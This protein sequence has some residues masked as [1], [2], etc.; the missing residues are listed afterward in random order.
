[1]KLIITEEM[2]YRKKVV[3]YAIKYQ[4]NAQAARRYGTS[5]QNVKRW[6]DRYDGTW[7][8][9]RPLSRR[10]NSHSKQHTGNELQLIKKTYQRY[11]H[12]GLAEVYVQCKQRGYCRTYESMCKQIRQQ[13]WNKHIQKR[14]RSYPKSRWKPDTVTYPGEKVQIDIKYVPQ[15]C[16]GFDSKGKQYYQIT[17][18]DEYSRKRVCKIVDEKSVT[19]TATFLLTLEEEMGFK[20]ITIQTDNGSEFT[21]EMLNTKK[22]SIFE[23]ILDYK[24]IK[25]RRTRPYSPWQ[26]GKVERSHR[27][28]SKW[29]G[30]RRFMSEAHLIKSHERYTHRGNNVHRKQLNFMSPNEVIAA[31]YSKSVA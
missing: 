10:P 19:H 20:I 18:L 26:N 22:K 27:E 16:I 23:E 1:M 12:E 2:R 3:E 28:D 5:R 11:R 17:A 14:E 6:R 30:K 21:N 31:Y 24:G 25:Y 13:G 29:Y 15:S 8:S 7:E 4:N 9:L